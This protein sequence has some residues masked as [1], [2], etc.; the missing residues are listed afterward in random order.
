MEPMTEERKKKY[1]EITSDG[2]M[3]VNISGLMQKQKVRK[4]YE[5]I[6]PQESVK[7]PSGQ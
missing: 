5:S 4:F 3:K 7:K 6:R 1:S 2:R